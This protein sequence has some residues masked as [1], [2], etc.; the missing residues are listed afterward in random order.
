MKFQ[1]SSIRSKTYFLILPLVSVILIGVI[2][3]AYYFSKM[4]IMDQTE[5]EML[6]TLSVSELKIQNRVTASSKVPEVFAKSI[7]DNYTKFSLAQYQTIASRNLEINMDTFGVGIF[8]EPYAYD[9][10][11]KY[12]ST[13]AYWNND[14]IA[15]SE[16][17]NEPSFD[18]PNQD[19]YVTSA[20]KRGIVF[21]DPYLDEVRQ[22]DMVTATVPIYSS[23][24]K[25]VG[26]TTGDII[27]TK[28]KEII[29]ETKVGSTGWT[30]LLDKNGTY[31]AGPETGKIMNVK[32]QEDKDP[33]LAALGKKLIEQKTGA[34][35]YT[36][37]NGELIKVYFQEMP[38][39]KWIVAIALPN[40]ELV[41]TLQAFVFKL[42][43]AS[44]LGVSFI[45]L[46][47]YYYSRSMTGQIS[48]VNDLSVYLSQG[49]F[50][51]A[52]SITTRDEFGQMIGN[53][54]QTTGLLR[55]MLTKVS[56]HAIAVAAT[57]EQL[58]ASADQ[59]SI[60]AEVISSTIEEVAAGA[61]AQMI[62]SRESAKSM[63][64]LAVGIQ[65]VAESSS[66]VWDVSQ[67]TSTKA[68]HGNK[69]IQNAVMDMNRANQ[70]VNDTAA[71]IDKLNERTLK[72]GSIVSIITGISTQTNLLS[73][74]A[75]I[76]AA[77]A[78]EHGK[79]FSVVAAEIRKLAEQS[80]TSAEQITALIAEIQKDMSDA[81]QSI[82]LGTQTVESGT[83]LVHQAGEAFSSILH[84]IQSMVDQIQE[85][86]ASSEQM[87]ASSQQVTA[88]VEEL[89][90]IA[91]EASDNS[92]NVAASSQEQLASMEEISSSSQELSKSMVELQELI[93]EFKI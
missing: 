63:E 93:S 45:V 11:T 54:N 58:S 91:V 79:G 80:R 33:V 68:I 40:K 88:T 1:F 27:L 46:V 7:G 77:R 62:G 18:Y 47:I 22:V 5:S 10:K 49:D 28:I 32:L 25:F 81:V 30:F 13:Y 4:I 3:F 17:Y 85:I 61:E 36:D 29:N 64:E 48:K 69:M 23:E 57:A 67:Q 41:Q 60:A 72:I 50:T 76:E 82:Q 74:N 70:T 71:L 38:D 52:V 6:N 89:L 19:F 75:S 37:K 43:I 20:N 53:F 83:G 16:E 51:H 31:L 84:D 87:S 55:E 92:Q 73:L 35:N 2:S 39:T 26:V 56:D 8:F 44:L 90:R 24:N 14:K 15:T 66:Q 42:I 34:Y 21:S 86:S 12:Y 9:A 59:S 65:R 78:G